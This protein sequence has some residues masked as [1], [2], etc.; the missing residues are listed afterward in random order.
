[1]NFVKEVLEGEAALHEKVERAQRNS[2]AADTLA[3]N[4][5]LPV[6]LSHPLLLRSTP[7]EQRAKEAKSRG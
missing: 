3:I 7:A 4:A 1:M 5:M 6:V 2:S